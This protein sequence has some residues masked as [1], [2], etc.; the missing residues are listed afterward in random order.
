MTTAK[1]LRI[2][3]NTVRQWITRIEDATTCERLAQAAAEMERLADY[4]Q[5]AERQLI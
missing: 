4:K 3:A 1:E 2:W 5:S